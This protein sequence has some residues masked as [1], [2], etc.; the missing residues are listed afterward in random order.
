MPQSE[1]RAASWR[2]AAVSF[3]GLALGVALLSSL[4]A[5]IFSPDAQ[6]T[7]WVSRPV[8]SSYDL[9]SGTEAAYRSDYKAGLWT[10]AVRAN[11]I[12][13]TGDVQTTSPWTAADTATALGAVSWDTGRRIVTR[14]GSGTAVPFRWSSLDSTQQ[15]ALG[16]A[17]TG[18]QMLNFLRGD[19]SNE[20]PSG[21]KL[22]ARAT[23]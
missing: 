14:T 11:N 21:T 8:L 9:R 2:R 10:G 23:V 13:A 1:T 12:N 19:R 6:P 7:G 5:T 3:G 4:A 20:A 15:G 22:R 18:P 16:T 17:T